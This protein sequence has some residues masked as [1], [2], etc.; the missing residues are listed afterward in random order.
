VSAIFTTG[1]DVGQALRNFMNVVVTNE[2]F[3]LSDAA[4]VAEAVPVSVAA[5]RDFAATDSL[6]SYAAL[7]YTSAGVLA[8]DNASVEFRAGVNLTVAGG[9]YQVPPNPTDSPTRH[10]PGADLTLIAAHFGTTPAAI[11]AVNVGQVP[12]TLA[13]LTAIKLP[14]VT[15]ASAGQSVQKLADYFGVPV[16]EVAAA[17]LDVEG[18][19]PAA[20]LKVSTGPA[21]L[22]PTV[23][24]GV[25]GMQL[26]R[27]APQVPETPGRD[28]AVEYL[29]QNFSLLGYR[30]ATNNGNDYFPQSAWGLPSGPI[31]PEATP[32]GDKI[33]APKAMLAGDPWNFAFSVPYAS[34]LAAGKGGVNP[35][36]GIGGILQF[37]LAWLDIFG[38]RILSELAN[39]VP[40]PGAPRQRP[41]QLLGYTDRLMGIGQWPAVAN[42]YR[43]VLDTTTHA[44]SLVLQLDFDAGSYQEA[45]KAIGGND[46]AAAQAGKHK[47]AQGI[48]AYTLI[49]EQLADPSGVRIELSTSVT[50]TAIWTLPDQPQ[51]GAPA[52]LRAWADTIL[53]YLQALENAPNT[54]PPAGYESAVALDAGAINTD[55]MFKLETRVTV[56]RR[57]PLVAGEL[58]TVDGVAEASTS[59]APFTGPLTTGNGKQP[60]R[61]LTAF[62]RDFTEAFASLDG[63]EL[64]I[65]T[66]A[67]RT[68]FTGTG[69]SP[70]WVVQL[71]A[72]GSGK[73]I[74]FTVKDCGSPTVYAPRP[75]SNVLA[76]R[77]STPIIQYTTGS[78]IQLRGPSVD[79]SFTSIDLDKWMATTLVF[80]DELFTPKYTMAADILRRN[81]ANVPRGNGAWPDALELLVDA[82]KKLASTLRAVM[83]PVYKGESANAQQ[84]TDIREAFYQT[85]LA[86]LGGFYGVA[87]GIQFTADV[88]AAIKPEPDATKVPRVFGDM[89][90]NGTKRADGTTISV[91]SPKL[92]LQFAA[93]GGV[94]P[95]SPYLSS[96]VSTTSVD[97]RS[98]SLTLEYE[99][100]Y[101]EHDIGRL[102]GIEG[103]EPSAWLSFVDIS[104]G[105]DG[106]NPLGAKLGT[107]PVPI[108]L[109]EFPPTPTLVN[110]DEVLKLTSPC[111]QPITAEAEASSAGS[112]LAGM[113]CVRTGTYD[114]LAAA[115]RWHYSFTYSLQVH[116]Q[117]DEIHGTVHFNVAEGSGVR[118]MADTGRDVFDNLAQF[119]QVY[120]QVRAD[121]N[122]YLVP[123][124]VDTTDETQLRNAQTALESAAAMI[125]WLGTSSPGLRDGDARLRTS[126]QVGSIK[127]TISEGDAPIGGVDALTITVELTA[128]L[129]P[130]VGAPFVEIAGYTCEPQSGGGGLTSVFAYK[131]NADGSYL[132]A[133]IGMNIAARSFVLPDLDI[134]E[135][136]DAQTEVFITRNADLVPRKTIADPF[137]YK[138]P[139][140]SFDQPLH[141]T[142]VVGD[143]INLATIFSTGRNA[144]VN[145][146]L[147]CQ[148]GLLYD[149]L[150]EN[151]GTDDVTMQASLY[152][153]YAIST[154]I[155]KVRLPVYLM[156]PT[157]T[158]LRDG[159]SGTPLADV[160]AM[161]VAGWTEWFDKHL[162][163][164][165]GGSLVLDLTLMSDLTA[166]PMPILHLTGLYVPYA[167]LA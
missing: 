160:I 62:A 127:F 119:T 98:V 134:L 8:K 129:P 147:D 122:T 154:G 38:N 3:D 48:A 111:S 43:V 59:I 136:Q 5:P 118:A 61:N 14:T 156:P 150:F 114:P 93:E 42:A 92:D 139:T 13:P 145:R 155:A 96:L 12:D 45:A 125:H 65:A 112:L 121:L 32:G 109:R 7:Y 153:E 143:A 51:M 102:A 126:A 110:Q 115:T 15:V 4:L 49:T 90:M 21:S 10:D 132:P 89:V 19:Y 77:A 34:V 91:S 81:I 9:L 37:E 137:V 46:P 54:P 29:R 39:P 23:R 165:T 151:A 105:G 94:T 82:K 144:P 53:T 88:K 50:P 40:V 69:T 22:A 66:G 106:A 25:A 73:P 157:Q 141:P 2:A 47:I 99:G 67:D 135:R 86:R 28:W 120:P 131:S 138:T 123:I 133:S 76:S 44:P 31:D 58:A 35:Y 75:I 107:F 70:L 71:G 101:I 60:Q 146:P 167:N 57:K 17:N 148:L 72:V 41:P 130:R 20:P 117:Q 163:E 11:R 100:Q 63:I 164:E 103:Y 128:Q 80:I 30:V 6:S 79:R 36:A 87:A 18:L 85:M 24:R 27:V 78:V 74:S 124:D 64:R 158:Q 152:Y 142:L 33:Q 108:V 104:D 113:Q 95:P 97:A 1:S 161:Q 166:R 56:R 84:L 162:P 68:Q 159:G 140:V 83:I 55:E 52:S 26:Q 16:P 149:A 116:R